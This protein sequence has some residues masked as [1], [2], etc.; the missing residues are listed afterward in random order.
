MPGPETGLGAG[1]ARPDARAL[2][3]SV[4]YRGAE[5]TA[6]RPGHQC[7]MTAGSVLESIDC[8]VLIWV[9]EDPS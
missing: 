5:F 4:R 3:P 6:A 9:V 7:A 8:S 2:C 1:T